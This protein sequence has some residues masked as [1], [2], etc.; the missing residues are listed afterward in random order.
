VQIHRSTVIN[1]DAVD[2][3]EEWSHQSFRIHIKGHGEPFAMSRRYAA[4]VRARLA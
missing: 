1:L 4:K 3:V 2:R